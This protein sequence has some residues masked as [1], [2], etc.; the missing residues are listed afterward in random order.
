MVRGRRSGESVA[1]FVLRDYGWRECEHSCRAGLHRGVV[2][3][4]ISDL[5]HSSFR[6]CFRS[7]DGFDPIRAVPTIQRVPPCRTDGDGDSW[8]GARRSPGGRSRPDE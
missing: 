4:K 8:L 2:G 5:G 3:S 1:E 7:Q 6:A